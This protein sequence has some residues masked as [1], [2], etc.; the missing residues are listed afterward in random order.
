MSHSR[1]ASLGI[2]LAAVAW[3]A[4][5]SVVGAAPAVHSGFDVS[6]SKP[7]YADYTLPENQD[8][9][10]ANVALTRGSLAGIYNVIQAPPNVSA[11][12]CLGTQFAR[13]S[14]DVILG[15]AGGAW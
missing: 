2:V 5:T 4:L 14:A 7:A 9:L 6:C 8:H 1:L 13:T 12:A 10:T 3:L 11:D 15:R